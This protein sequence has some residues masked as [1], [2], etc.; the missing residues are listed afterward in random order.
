MSVPLESSAR[1]DIPMLPK[2]K[3]HPEHYL[4]GAK[5]PHAVRLL[6]EPHPDPTGALGA[7]H[8]QPRMPLRSQELYEP[9]PDREYGE[10][11]DESPLP[12]SALLLVLFLCLTSLLISV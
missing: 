2:G 9:I 10:F 7:Y 1:L 8:P 11:L 12:H 6:D 3:P 4:G 5:D